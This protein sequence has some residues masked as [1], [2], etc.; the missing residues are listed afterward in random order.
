MD[1]NTYAIE[2][3]VEATHWWFTERRWLFGRLIRDLGLAPNAR[4]LD[5]GTSTG[6]NLRLLRDLGFH[7]AEG[8]DASPEAVQ[9][10]M[11]K[12]YGKVTAGD[13]CKLP[14]PDQTFDLIL[15]TDIIEH[16]DDDTLA[17][18]E[19]HRVL[20]PAGH[21]LITVP[22]FPLLWGVQDEVGQHKRRYRARELLARMDLVGLRA[23]KRF[24]FNY[25]LFLPIL[26]VRLVIRGLRLQVRSENQI[27]SR[28][29][30]RVLQCI[31]RFDV[32]TAQY[33]RPPFGVSYLALARRR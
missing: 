23:V 21:V 3:Q 27:N 18:R 7:N 11:E 17:L 32:W 33:L 29:I 25:L 24:Y 4:I 14:F 8:L 2:A 1:S 9:W 16:V 22:A 30:N 31:F 10:C 13:V 19:I 28:A 12:G 5:I 15:A 26:C 20:K 6:T